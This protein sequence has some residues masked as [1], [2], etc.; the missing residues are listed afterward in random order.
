MPNASCVDCG[1][2][3]IREFVETRRN[4]RE[5]PMAARLSRHCH[6]ISPTIVLQGHAEAHWRYK[7]IATRWY[8]SPSS[9]I[10][11]LAELN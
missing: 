6:A 11:T 8:Q 9:M 2:S 3:Q 1:R 5:T 7:R 4:A 10:F